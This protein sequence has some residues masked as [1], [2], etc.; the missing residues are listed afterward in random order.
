MKIDEAVEMTMP[1]VVTSY[2]TSEKVYDVTRSFHKGSDDLF[3][4]VCKK[5]ASRGIDVVDDC[6]EDAYKIIVNIDHDGEALDENDAKTLIEH[7]NAEIKSEVYSRK[8]KLMQ[9]G[10]VFGIVS[11]RHKSSNP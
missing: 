11:S 7:V 10:L 6:F 2:V 1:Y 5:I 9:A 4:D 3:L 8:G